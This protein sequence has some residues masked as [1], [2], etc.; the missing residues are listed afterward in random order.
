M[1]QSALL[2][3]TPGDAVSIHSAYTGRA[4]Q[5]GVVVKVCMRWI[6][7]RRPDYRTPTR[8]RT[9]GPLAGHEI[10]HRDSDALRDYIR[11]V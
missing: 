6:E 5:S 8:Y 10:V 4:Y 2:S 7:V 3:L 11:A 1:S 9:S